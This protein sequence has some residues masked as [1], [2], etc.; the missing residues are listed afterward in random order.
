[1][2]KRKFPEQVLFR[3]KKPCYL[4]AIRD[5]TEIIARRMGFDEDQVF[6]LTM[7]VDEAYTNAVEH[8]GMR[9]DGSDL[10]VEFLI[11]KD[12]LEV[13]V[14]DTG[15]GFDLSCVQIPA[16]L[17]SLTS[18][19]GRG[20]GL[21]SMLSDSYELTSSPDTGTVLRLIKYIC[22]QREYVA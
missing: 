16:N 14:K 22:A 13:C 5:N 3:F 18:T 2:K 1:M 19:R 15:C 9:P 20:L 12:R 4:R 8:G 21:I 11:F 10:E 7:I 6:E 17:R